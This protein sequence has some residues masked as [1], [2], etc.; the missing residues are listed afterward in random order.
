MCDFCTRSSW[1]TSIRGVLYHETEKTTRVSFNHY[2]IINM[3]QFLVGCFFLKS[4]S[5]EED[6]RGTSIC[7]VLIFEWPEFCSKVSVGTYIQ[8]VIVFD[9]YLCILPSLQYILMYM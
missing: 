4:L 1:G 3:I 6:N 7:G 8:R 9:V 5:K 2:K